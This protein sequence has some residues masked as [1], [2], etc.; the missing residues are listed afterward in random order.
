LSGGASIEGQTVS[1]SSLQT[2]IVL[3]SDKVELTITEITVVGKKHLITA[4]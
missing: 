1:I 2:P 4:S 3:L